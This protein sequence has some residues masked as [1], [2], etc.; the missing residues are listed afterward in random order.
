MLTSLCFITFNFH[1][2]VYYNNFV[3]LSGELTLT[4][5]HCMVF[6]SLYYKMRVPIRS[7][8]VAEMLQNMFKL[9]FHGFKYPEVHYRNHKEGKSS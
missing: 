1:I 9:H 6:V 5:L 2:I 8:T 7:W 3:V 4:L